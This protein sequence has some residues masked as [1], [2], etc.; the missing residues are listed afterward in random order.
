MTWRE[1]RLAG[2]VLLSAACVLVLGHGVHTGFERVRFRVVA[3]PLSVT[4]P[5][6]TF[7]LPDLTPLAGGPAAIILRVSGAAAPVRLT[8]LLDSHVV[9]RL[10]VP[11]SRAM[12]VDLSAEAPL[13]AGHHLTLMGDRTGWRLDSL[14]IGNFHGFSTG[15]LSF[16]IVPDTRRVDT[17]S[18]WLLPPIFIALSLMRPRFDWP[19][20]AR[21][22]LV[23]RGA[24]AVVLLLY[25]CTLVAPMLTPYR[26]V[27]SVETLLLAAAILYA[28]P[29][30]RVWTSLARLRQSLALVPLALPHIAIA[31]LFLDTLAESYRPETG[32]T[33]LIQFSEWFQP[34]AIPALRETPHLVF[35]GTG[36]DGQFYAQLALDPLLRDDATLRA[37]DAPS[38]RARRIL[39]PWVAWSAGLGRPWLI[40]QAYALLNVVSWIALGW[41]L[42]RWLRPGSLSATAAWAAC[43]LNC[44][45]RES[46]G[47][48]LTD[49]PSL[50]LIA[51]AVV[52]IEGNRRWLATLVMAL[53]GL[54]RE[55]NLVGGVGLCAHPGSTRPRTARDAVHLI[56]IAAPL[57]LWMT[58]LIARGLP[59][60]DPAAGNITLPLF[61]YVET[62]LRTLRNLLGGDA[63]AW[64]TMMTLVA[65]GAQVL[66]LLRYPDRTHP[67]WRVGLGYVAL[68]FVLGDKVWSSGDAAPRS[69]L[70]M[71][72][73][74]NVLLSQRSGQ[75]PKTFWTWFVLGNANLV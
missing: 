7:P 51:L 61:A 3:T 55:T 47:A 9:T 15:P 75:A 69:L 39:L 5:S 34:Q 20:H 64:H 46:I 16:V 21:L 25:A 12:R 62:W 65:V 66:M 52:I 43:M 14:Q 50:L 67:W 70:P 73:A 40:L 35:P 10:S 38:Y 58:Y 45:F 41:L 33:S 29:L 72:V 26:V 48:A 1:S 36:H 68:M 56:V 63:T 32:L 8:V 42:L 71:T 49:G 2:S 17:V 24:T 74:F 23:H 22:R 18:P 6:L 60:V 59:F 13:D 19:A 37:L 54:A 30:A 11:P 28:E 44:G 53:A 31:L 27:L 4:E 57:L